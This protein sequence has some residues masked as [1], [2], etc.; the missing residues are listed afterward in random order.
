MTR[1]LTAAVCLLTLIGPKIMLAED[2]H[3]QITAAL[4]QQVEAWNRGD[5]ETFVG[6]YAA[7]CIFVGKTV[8]HGREQLLARYRATYPNREAMGRLTF[9]TLEVRI[10]DDDVA[11][12]TGEWRLERSASGGGAKS[13]LFSLVFKRTGGEW[14]IALDHTS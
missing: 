5:V 4:N 8:A 9:S 11:I 2:A 7:D 10:L 12:V 6:T 14:K 3:T 1:P 13:G